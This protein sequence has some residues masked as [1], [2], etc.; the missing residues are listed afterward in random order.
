MPKVKT[1]A[2]NLGQAQAVKVKTRALILG[3]TQ[4]LDV[5]FQRQGQMTYVKE[6]LMHEMNI[7]SKSKTRAA[8]VGQT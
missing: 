3:Q 7:C 5:R 8:N 1:R 2:Q 6:V 4:T